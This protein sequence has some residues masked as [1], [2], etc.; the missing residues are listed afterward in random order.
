M[1]S[2][3]TASPRAKAATAR[4][5]R[6]AACGNAAASTAAARSCR[7]DRSAPSTADRPVPTTC[8]CGWASSPSITSDVGA[9]TASIPIGCISPSRQRNVPTYTSPMR[10]SMVARIGMTSAAVV[11]PASDGSGAEGSARIARTANVEM[12][13]TGR[14]SA[15]A[16][17]CAMAIARRTPVNAPGP[18]P[19]AI[20]SSCARAMPASAS[21]ISAHGRASSAWRRGAISNRSRTAPSTCSAME[22][23]S[24]EVSMA[25]SFMAIAVWR[26]VPQ[27]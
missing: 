12:G 13:N 16:M 22:Q 25:S 3:A 9:P 27:A 15:S 21:S 5:A 6:S 8:Q 24:V 23:A 14:S 1:A 4:V 11:G 26:F 17:P 20:A 19:T 10:A 2:G 7:R 18:R